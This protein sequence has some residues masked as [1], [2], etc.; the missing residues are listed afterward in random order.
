[1]GEYVALNRRIYNLLLKQEVV[2][3]PVTA[4]F[5]FLVALLEENLIYVQ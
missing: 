5:F 1:M 4:T 2:A 3:F